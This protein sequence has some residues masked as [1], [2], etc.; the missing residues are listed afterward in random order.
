[1]ADDER[2]VTDY[3]RFYTAPRAQ[4]ERLVESLGLNVP[5]AEI[6]RAVASLTA[7]GAP[8]EVVNDVS[9]LPP[10]IRDLFETLLESATSFPRLARAE[11]R[12]RVAADEQGSED[13]PEAVAAQRAELERLRLELARRRGQVEAI[14][15]QLDVRTMS[16]NE[17]R[18]VIHDLHEQ[19]VERDDEIASLRADLMRRL[20]AEDCLRRAVDALEDK[21]AS[22]ETT[23]LWRLG[24]RYWSLKR[25]IRS[26]V[27]RGKP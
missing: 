14:Q 4:V 3:S 5:S 11:T 9:E 18:Q 13:L 23:R 15:V 21:L 19:L 20:D 27:G 16:E 8:P 26:A 6:D 7:S 25:S 24:K 10:E 1:M 17:L 22:V 2:I 12:A